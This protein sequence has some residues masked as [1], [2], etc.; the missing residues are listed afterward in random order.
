M[1]LKA[2]VAEVTNVAQV[3]SGWG[4]AIYPIPSGLTYVCALSRPTAMLV[5]RLCH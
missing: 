2:L 5:V 4:V 1:G 3:N